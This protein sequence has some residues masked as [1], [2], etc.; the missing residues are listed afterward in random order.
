MPRLRLLPPVEAAYTPEEAAPILRYL[1]NRGGPVAIDTETTGLQIMKDRVLYWSMATESRRF[2][3]PVELLYYFDPLFQRPDVTWYLANAKYDMHLLANMGVTL[4][5]DVWDIVVMDAMEDD[6][7]SHGL[8]EQA[9]LAYGVRWGEFKN[10]FLDNNDQQLDKIT[11]A[12][13]RE[14]SVGD[15]LEFVFRESPEVVENYA[16]CD[17]FFTYMRAEDLRSQLSSQPLPTEVCASFSYL[18]DYFRVIEVPLTKVLW[19]MER[20]GFMV[21][22]D[23]V[24]SIDGPMRD[25]VA[26]AEKRIYEAAGYRINPR[27][28]D[29]LREI[30]F[31]KDKGFGLKPIKYTASDDPKASTDDKSLDLLSL[32]AGVGT[33]AQKFINAV[34]DYRHIVKL[35]GTYVKNLHKLVWGKG[36][37][38][39][40]RVHCRINQ[41]GARTSRLSSADPNM[42][43]IPA[44]NDEYKIR[45]VFVADPGT[46]LVDFDYPQIEFRIAAYLAGEEAMMEPI[47]KGWD[48]HSANGGHM[49]RK[50]GVTYEGIMEARRKKDAKEPLTDRDRMLLKK[51]DHSKEI[52]LANLYGKGAPK[53]AAE[54]KITLEE[55]EELQNDFARAYPNIAGQI[56]DMKSFAHEHEFTHTWLG[57]IRRLYRINNEHNRGLVGAEERQAYNTLVQGTGAEMIKL[58]MLRIAHDKRFKELGGRL[59]L[60][61]HDELISRCPKDT[62]KD[63][64]KVKKELMSEPFK[65]GPINIDLPVPVDPDGQIGHRWSELK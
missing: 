39:D 16:S 29:D 17:A 27:S 35:H 62:S 61:V 11:R 1:M 21:D 57:R 54:L 3:F 48:I 24:K 64:F 33:P 4:V 18:I 28:T 41:A 44:R 42:Q 20:A 6:T 40:G 14:M 19:D 9:F 23:Y 15:K 37:N 45:G 52:G 8:K 47:R 31:N 38:G 59:I 63:L 58:A 25:G 51:R 55:A 13:F 49:F 32:R 46:D 43:N 22:M 10:L 36:D 12:A 7:R 5:G 53:L 26:A 65:W 56:R 34:Q 2:F 30:L 50:D 60:T